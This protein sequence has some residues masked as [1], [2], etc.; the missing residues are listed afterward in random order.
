MVTAKP[1]GLMH[2]LIQNIIINQSII[3]HLV[4]G[5]GVAGSEIQGHPGLDGEVQTSQDYRVRLYIKSSLW[6]SGRF[7][8]H[9]CGVT[10]S[11]SA[12]GL[13]GMGSVPSGGCLPSNLGYDPFCRVTPDHSSSSEDRP[14][15]CQQLDLHLHLAS[16]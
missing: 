2:T 6:P 4:G 5:G 15:W 7:L 10:S 14:P 9:E 11:S 13:G 16:V 8:L 12:C 3:Q 1:N